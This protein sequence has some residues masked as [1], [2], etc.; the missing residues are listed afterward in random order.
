MTHRIQNGSRVVVVIVTDAGFSSRL[1]VNNG[2]TATLLSAKH[3]TLA[4]AQKWAA[5]VMA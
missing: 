3:K 1:Y 2:E 5:K 4:G